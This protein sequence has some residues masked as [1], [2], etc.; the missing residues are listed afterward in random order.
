MKKIFF[1]LLVHENK[2]CFKDLF[3]NILYYASDF[4]VNLLISTTIDAYTFV[5][6]LAD[7]Y[8]NIHIVTVR[9]NNVKIW[10]NIELFNQHILNIK[11]LIDNNIQFDYLWFMASNELFIKH[12]TEEHLDKH[13]IRIDGNKNCKKSFV[14]EEFKDEMILHQNK[15][16]HY[17]E[18]QFKKDSYTYSIFKDNLIF[19]QIE[20]LVL[21]EGLA[22]EIHNKYNEYNIYNIRNFNDYN[23]EELFIQSYL[24]LTYGIKNIN[25][26]CFRYLMSSDSNINNFN[27]TESLYLTC[28]NHPHALSIKPV[29]RCINDPLRIAIR[30]KMEHVGDIMNKYKFI[31]TKKY[32]SNNFSCRVEIKDDVVNFSKLTKKQTDYCWIGYSISSPGDYKVSFEIYSDKLID[33]D[34]IKLHNPIRFCSVQPINP[35]SWT[36]VDILIN[37]INPNDLLC[38]IFDNY[39]DQIN[40]KFKNINIINVNNDK[41]NIIVEIVN[42]SIKTKPLCF[43][44]G[45]CRLLKMIGEGVEKI[46]PLQA[47]FH[48]DL[49]GINF[50]GKLNTTQQHIQFINFLK[51][52]VEIPSHILKY[53]LTAYNYEKWQRIRSFDNCDTIDGKIN[54]INN[55]FNES[56]YFVFEIS[57][58]KSYTME[59]FHIQYEQFDNNCPLGCNF[60]IQSK[61]ELINDLN[62]LI[63]LV[64]INKKIIFICHFRPNIIYNNPSLSIANRELI[65]ET[66]LEISKNNKNIELYDPS[67]IISQN[68][69]YIV[70]P[71]QYS[72]IGYKKSFDCLYNN[73]LRPKNIALIIPIYPPHYQVMYNF[74]NKNVTDIIDIFLVFS[75]QH[76]CELFD[77]KQKIK[78]LILPNNFKTGNII[79][80]KKFWALT[81]LM[82][83]IDYD[84]FIVC[85]AEIDIIPENFTMDNI[86]NKVE[87]IFKNKKIFGGET[88]GTF[89]TNLINTQSASLFCLD[90][91]NKLN[92]LTNNFNLYYWWSDVPVYKREHLPDFFNKISQLV[93]P[94]QIRSLCHRVVANHLR[95]L[96]QDK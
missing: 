64:P 88:N 51:G 39:T 73:F 9:D 80:Y 75:N 84:Y 27:D 92:E 20:G 41:Q 86:S 77:Q 42:K 14:N 46:Q 36:T 48:N 67:I 6:E 91:Y 87:S 62:T 72:E 93:L 31:N 35:Y 43:V 63:Q 23:L 95:P 70:D 45:T 22:F 3:N 94:K 85:D 34:F 5:K 19:Y 25:Y 17:W 44:S 56:D 52:N 30:N 16:Y 71:E 15:R 21:D 61:D 47:M 4:E 60:Y 54:F 37:K 13:I 1:S 28:Y 78:P 66:L 68:T 33:F 2:D 40:V 11:Y 26:F 65:Y 59:G 79:T 55:H 53:F 89:G 81:L 12:I 49:A 32:F 76:D 82:N 57:S 24:N 10:G 7:I 90:D 29:N 74:L 96:L 58:I 38:F 18:D 83:N 50:L 69:D 8:E